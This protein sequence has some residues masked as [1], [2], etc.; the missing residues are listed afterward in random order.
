MKK[1]R[2][3]AIGDIH[4]EFYKLENLLKK[5]DLKNN[6]TCVFTGD[7]IDMGKYSKDVVS[8]LIELSKE[9]NC[10]FLKGN[11]EDMLLKAKNNEFKAV[12]NW[13]LMGGDTTLK[14]YGEEVKD[15]FNIHGKFFENLKI[16]YITDKYFFV[17]GGINPD[18]PYKEQTEKDFLWYRHDFIEKTFGIPQKVV[19]G[20][21]NCVEPYIDKYSIGIDTGC[22]KLEDAKLTAFICYDEI[23]IQSDVV[24]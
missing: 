22:G 13:Y 7:Y 19:F 15:I 4:G 21:T 11:H 20:H 14:S 10:I 2:L 16:N 5:L 8:R 6:D 24:W 18:K 9:T 23:F 1:G 12:A 17:H 3:I